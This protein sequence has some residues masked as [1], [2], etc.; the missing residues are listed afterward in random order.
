VHLGCFTCDGIQLKL[1]QNARGCPLGMTVIQPL[2][3]LMQFQA[4]LMQNVDSVEGFSYSAVHRAD[5]RGKTMSHVI[6]KP[7]IPSLVQAKSCL[8]CEATHKQP[9]PCQLSTIGGDLIV[10]PVSTTASWCPVAMP[11]KYR[12]PLLHPT[13]TAC[14]HV[15]HLVCSQLL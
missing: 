8:P 6:I 13:T 5:Q 3:E 4:H 7:R 15:Q 9:Q 2:L 10:P 14:I 12:L 1:A 11:R